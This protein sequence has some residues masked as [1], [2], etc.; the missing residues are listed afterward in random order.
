MTDSMRRAVAILLVIGGTAALWWA[1]GPTVNDSAS[2][3][4]VINATMDQVR[5]S[6]AANNPLLKGSYRF[7]R[8]GW[9]Y[10]HLQGD[11]A[12]IGYQHGYLLGPE[13]EDA[14]AATSSGMMHST[15]R[16]WAFFRKTAQEML[17]P[18]IDAEYQQELE[19]IVKG[20]HARTGSKLDIYDFVALYAMEEV[21]DYYVPWL[22]KWEHPPNAPKLKSPG[23][24]S[25]FVATGS[26]T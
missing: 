4:S 15:G 11:P 5:A 17:W 14:F 8:G 3:Q 21:P 26:W 1:G 20:L 23:N 25:A 12:A 13:I 7:E 18:K 2:A 9:I 6:E 19:G 24:C 10:V 16:D 22:N